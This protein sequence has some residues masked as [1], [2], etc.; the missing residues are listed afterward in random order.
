MRLACASHSNA[1]RMQITASLQFCRVHDQHLSLDRAHALPCECMKHDRSG[2]PAHSTCRALVPRDGRCQ[3]GTLCGVTPLRRSPH[4]TS[5]AA[6]ALLVLPPWA[7]RPIVCGLPR[8]TVPML[9]GSRPP[10]Q[11]QCRRRRPPLRPVARRPAD[12]RL[13]AVERACVAAIGAPPSRATHGE[14]GLRG[15]EPA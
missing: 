7:S 1:E 9:A 11:R 12:L 2:A 5:T 8:S 10:Y 6:D 3:E 14:L 13:G 4:C 15:R